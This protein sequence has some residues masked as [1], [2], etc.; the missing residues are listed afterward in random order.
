[1]FKI[2][3]TKGCGKTK[4]IINEASKAANGTIVCSNPDAIKYKIKQYGLRDIECISYEEFLQYHQHDHIRRF[5][6]DEIDMLLEYLN[7]NINGYTC[8]IE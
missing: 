2:F 3:G 5:Y 4:Q 1:M 8:S 6:I 7:P